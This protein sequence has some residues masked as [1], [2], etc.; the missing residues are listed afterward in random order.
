M[1][2]VNNYYLS[3]ISFSA[4]SLGW[5]TEKGPSLKKLGVGLLVVTN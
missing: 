4:L 5:V 1:M 2:I 3:I